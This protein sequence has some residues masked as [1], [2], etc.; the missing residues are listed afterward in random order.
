MNANLVY[1]Q[2]HANIE[3]FQTLHS[4]CTLIIHHY[5]VKSYHFTIFSLEK[6]ERYLTEIIK[7]TTE[8]GIHI[9]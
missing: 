8:T 9:C 1:L 6:K 3:Q 4:L 5:G 7:T 2:T